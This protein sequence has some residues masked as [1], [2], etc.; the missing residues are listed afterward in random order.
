VN[1]Q[2]GI[3]L[4]LAAACAGAERPKPDKQGPQIE[5]MLR[6][7]PLPAPSQEGWSTPDRLGMPRPISFPDTEPY[8]PNPPLAPGEEGS[9]VLRVMV[10]PTGD[11]WDAEVLEEKPRDNGLGTS[12]LRYIRAV[13]FTPAIVRG[14]AAAMRVTYVLR[15]R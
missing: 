11:V 8:A 2:T 13:K 1:G 5:M 12:A 6:R 15:F 4:A 9:V 7:D 10:S 3:A 14:R